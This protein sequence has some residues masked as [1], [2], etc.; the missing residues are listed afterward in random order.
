MSRARRR[1][2]RTVRGHVY[3]P[4]QTTY[5][6]TERRRAAAWKSVTQTLPD[7]AKQPAPYRS[8]DGR[9]GRAAYDFCL[10]LEHARLSLLAEVRD[11]SLSMFA[12]LGIPWHAGVDGGPSNHLLSS[13]VQCVNA[14]DQMVHDPHRLL[15]AF[16]DVLN[17]AEVLEVEP[18]RYLTFEYIGPTD[19]FGEAAGAERIRGAHCTS[20]D[21]AF[22]HVR[23]DG[24]RELALVEW[25]YTEHYALRRPDPHKDEVRRGRYG[26]AWAAPD[27]PVRTDVLPFELVLDEPFY[28]LVRQQLLAHELEKARAHGADRVRV[29]HVLPCRNDAYQQSLIRPEHR[30]AGASVSA[31]WQRMLRRPDRF[32]SLDSALFLDPSITSD[33]YALRYRGDA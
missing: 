27:S 32:M 20:V 21:A 1:S 25:K 9:T 6:A 15:R 13:Q 19:F 4:R 7:E 8:K 5:T 3:G 11:S 23:R 30:A 16:G 18:G 31:V 33:E 29:V 26:Q 22:L 2:T 28:Q 24:L 12:E 14:L 17:I 10:P